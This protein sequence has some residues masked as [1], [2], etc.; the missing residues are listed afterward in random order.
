MKDKITTYLNRYARSDQGTEGVFS[1]PDLAF[2]CFCLELP[3]RD[4]RPDVSCIPPGLYPLSWS[5][6]NKAYQVQNVPGRS[7]ILIH[8]GNFAGDEAL[9]YKSDVEGCILLGMHMGHIEKQRCL[10]SSRIAIKKFQDLISGRTADL[11]VTGVPKVVN[12]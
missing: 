8:A 4:N 1:V 3:W 12:G 10:T 5:D 2:A 6:R 7:G 9:G 11:I